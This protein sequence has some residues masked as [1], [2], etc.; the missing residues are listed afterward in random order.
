MPTESHDTLTAF[1]S[2]DAAAERIGAIVESA[3]VRALPQALDLYQLPSR[4]G[5]D[6][7]KMK[8]LPE[9]WNDLSKNVRDTITKVDENSV[10]IKSHNELLRTKMNWRKLK[11]S[12]KE[13][14]ELGDE[15]FHVRKKWK[16]L[17]PITTGIILFFG[18]PVVHKLLN[19]FL[20]LFGW[21]VE[22]E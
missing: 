20:G 9:A 11:K 7:V 17:I 5:S 18:S 2:T 8:P 19:I 12:V 15:T 22:I 21:K 16:I 10:I 4:N 14:V 3:V 6:A 1:L 13:V